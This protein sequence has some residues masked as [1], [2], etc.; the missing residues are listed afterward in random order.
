VVTQ[1]ISNLI[2]EGK[3]HMIY[4]AI[5][6]G[7]QLGM[8]TMDRS[9]AETIKHGLVDPEVALAKAHNADQVRSLAGLR[10]TVAAGPR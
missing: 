3:P 2:R 8:M 4:T 10:P 1:A 7:S 9:L 5:E 6:T